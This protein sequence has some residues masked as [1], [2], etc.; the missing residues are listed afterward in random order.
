MKKLVAISIFLITGIAGFSQVKE[1]MVKNSAKGPYLDHTVEAKEGLFAIGRIYNAHPRHIANFNNI[2]FNKGLAIGQIIHVPLT[3]TNFVKDTDTGVP[4]YYITEREESVANL[5]VRYNIPAT[6]LRSWNLLQDSKINN[7]SKLVVGFLNT[8]EMADMVITIPEKVIGNT[9]LPETL[10]SAS[11]AETKNVVE[12]VM[13]NTE[14][15]KAELVEE[16][17]LQV[18]PLVEK[19]PEPEVK[20]E[21]PK[22]VPVVIAKQPESISDNGSGYFRASFIEQ[23]KVSPT[24]KEQTVTSSIFKTTSGWEDTKYYLLINDVAPGTIIKIT[25]PSNNKSVYAKVLYAMDKIRQNQ[26]VDIRI[27]DAA[28]SRLAITETDKFVVQ[29]DF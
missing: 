9:P 10:K 3:D 29:L 24:S 11:N 21:E 8:T 23:V 14:E 16:K 6:K 12:E 15:K 19:K 5:S 7:G 13:N 20:K 27:S 4:V 25:N 17:P 1:L 2:D 22:T 18:K 28:A 26:G